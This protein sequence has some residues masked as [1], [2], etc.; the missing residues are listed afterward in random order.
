MGFAPQ[1]EAFGRNGEA[2]DS[3]STISSM[4]LIARK[5]LPA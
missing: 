2:I 5:P 4:M 1:A 3:H